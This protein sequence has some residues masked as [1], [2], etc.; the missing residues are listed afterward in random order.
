MLRKGYSDARTSI[1]QIQ[2]QMLV[3][4]FIVHTAHNEIVIDHK[5]ILLAIDAAV[6]LM[7]NPM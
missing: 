3:N 6:V 4:Y 5:C 7:A 1:L 2:R